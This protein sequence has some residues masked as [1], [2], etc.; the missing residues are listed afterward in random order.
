MPRPAKPYVERGWY[1]SR[2]GGEYVRLCP[3]SEGSQRAKQLL[4]EHLQ[5]REREKEQNGGRLPLR[6]TVTDLFLE[7]LPAVEAEKSKHTLL[8]YQKWCTRFARIH[9]SRL[10]RD[11]TRYDA[12]KFK[13]DLLNQTWVRNRQPPKKYK[14]K[15][16]NHAIISLKR[17]FNWAIENE[18]LPEGR[19]PFARVK[20]LPVQGRQRTATAEEFE[21]LLRH[22]TDGH[23]RDVLI[24]MRYTPAR[25]GDIRNLTWA[26]VQFD[27]RVWFI[28]QHKTTRTAREPRPFVIGLNDELERMLL[29]RRAQAE[30]EGRYAD[31]ERVFLNREGKPWTR[32]AL[33]LRMRR[34]RKRAGILPDANGEE[35]VLYTNRHTFLTQAGMDPTIPDSVRMILARHTDGRTT[36][37][38]THHSEYVAA[39]AGR[40]VADSIRDQETR[41]G[42]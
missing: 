29:D 28:T 22:C 1:I 21:A 31:H 5:K 3:E 9:G 16:I 40:R 19:N 15:S 6:L 13:Q 32:N 35:F 12:E 39:D 17:A 34:L 26:M 42:M 27:K 8:E 14:P 11:V 2:P 4:R 30:E 36:Q 38:Y 25:P 41:S 37:H 24:A 20:L 10:A 23:F 33:G 7:F 18:L